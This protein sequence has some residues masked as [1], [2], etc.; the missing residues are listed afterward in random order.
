MTF[1]LRRFAQV[2]DPIGYI[3]YNWSVRSQKVLLIR[4]PHFHDPIRDDRWFVFQISNQRKT[5][6]WSRSKNTVCLI[7]N[8]DIPQF[9]FSQKKKN[10]EPGSTNVLYPV[11]G[12]LVFTFGLGRASN[13]FQSLFHQFGSVKILFSDLSI[14]ILMSVCDDRLFDYKRKVNFAFECKGFGG[15]VFV[16]DL[17]RDIDIRR[18]WSNVCRFQ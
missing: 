11:P 17:R 15:R 6:S 8:L 3:R 18:W 14:S 9:Y 13:V 2:I 1:F 5:F 16:F 12:C 4:D 7:I 10:T